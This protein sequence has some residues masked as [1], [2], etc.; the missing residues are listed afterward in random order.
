MTQSPANVSKRSWLCV[1]AHVFSFSLSTF[2]LSTYV[3]T[4]NQSSKTSYTVTARVFPFTVFFPTFQSFSPQVLRL[5]LIF[6]WTIDQVFEERLIETLQ[7]LTENPI[8]NPQREFICFEELP[9][10]GI[11][12]S[13]HGLGFPSKR[14]L[15]GHVIRLAHAAPHGEATTSGS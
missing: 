7:H 6:F 12:A 2:S 1:I 9:G 4:P 8:G 14:Y 5:R 11:P 15:R 3:V 13:K 10:G